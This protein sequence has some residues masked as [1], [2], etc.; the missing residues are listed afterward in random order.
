MIP[1]FSG[2]H[3]PFNKPFFKDHIDFQGEMIPM[4]SGSHNPFAHFSEK[5]SHFL[6]MHH[7]EP[8]Q[9]PHQYF[10]HEPVS[11]FEP[12]GYTE[13]PY[14]MTPTH[15]RPFFTHDH[16]V[17]VDEPHHNAHVHGDMYAG[18]G[19]T[20]T[21]DS[22]GLNGQGLKSNHFDKVTAGAGSTVNFGLLI[23]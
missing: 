3:N 9:Q 21:F 4:F 2:P 10:H 17:Y 19:Q 14:S 1:M 13:V 22:H 7:S 6:P 8:V 12:Y 15:W 18:Q 23:Q 20:M 5:F 11:H 16:Q